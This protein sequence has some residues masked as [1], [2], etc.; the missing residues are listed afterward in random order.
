M[1]GILG[2][3]QRPDRAVNVGRFAESLQSMRHRG[4]DGEG[5]YLLNSASGAGAAWAGSDTD[6]RLRLPA[7]AGAAG[8]RAN[9]ALGH[10]R[11]AII[12]LSPSGHQPM[13]SRDRRQ[14]IVLN[15]EVYN[16]RELRSELRGRGHSFVSSSDTE[17]V[18]AAYREWGPLSV[19]RFV[20]MF[21][22]A[23]ID[24]PRRAVFLARDHFGIK[25]LYYAFDGRQL[26]FAS[27]IGPLLRLRGGRP[28]IDPR[29]TYEYL[30]YNLS[31][32]G[33]ATMFQGISQLPAASTMELSWEH[34]RLSGPTAYWRI[35]GVAP[36]DIGRPEAARELRRL[37]EESVGY[38][39]R[40]DVPVGSC[41]SGGLD[42]SAIV[43]M[44]RQ[45]LGPRRSIQTFSYVSDDRLLSE[46]RYIDM[47]NGA[48]ACVPHKTTISPDELAR[49]L[50]SLIRVQE[51]PFMST[52]IYAQ[53]RVFRLAGECGIKVMLDG[54]GADELFAGYLNL[55]GARITALLAGRDW[56]G[57]RRLCR[58]VP[59]NMGGYRFGMLATA[60]GRLAPARL[61]GQMMAA[62]GQPIWPS[63]LNPGWFAERG[64]AAAP[65]AYGRG[66]QALREELRLAIEQASLP[67]L[68]RFEDRNSM[69]HSI[70]SRV[71]FCNHRLAEFAFSLPDDYL[72]DGSG[73]TKAILKQSLG[74]V[75]PEEIL[76]REKV[77]FAVPE[78][79]WAVQ[80]A[81]WIERILAGAHDD[82]FPMLDLPKV[83]KTVRR[84]MED[85][86]RHL[87]GESWRIVL[88][89]RWAAIWGA[90]VA[91]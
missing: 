52:S 89:I 11:L 2:L 5:I 42:S 45:R 58:A 27:E 55:L 7:V 12:D 35:D 72:I 65:R 4:P 57:A 49:D 53:Y 54:Q 20:G 85:G 83:R 44:M 66:R 10:R 24:I 19:G 8:S 36:S 14:W 25:P 37:L 76:N 23:I 59:L 63:W 40:S 71:P 60:L 90:D 77:G 38:H 87:L 21:A 81:P 43:A 78:R 32:Y 22:L 34:M 16:Y 47:V 30:R 1:C 75:L 68:L 15:G 82:G 9:I 69:A 29:R 33:D 61:H 48:N 18:L 86:R 41:L 39:L 31:D 50:D 88:F 80:L 46:E 3:I 51:L 73:T 64:V 17:V 74:G 84:Q 91:A 67:N 79:R 26:A 70:E 6:P 13:A 62:A 56:S 28:R